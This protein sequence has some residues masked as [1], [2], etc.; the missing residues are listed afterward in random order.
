M[1]LR[2]HFHPPLSVTHPWKAFHSAWANAITKQLNEVL[3]ESYYAIPDVPRGDE[4]V[5]TPLQLRLAGSVDDPGVH[6][7]AVHIL[8][9][10]G[11]PRLRAAIELVSPQNKDCPRSRLPLAA[12]C[13][14]YLQRAVSVVLVDTVT[15]CHGNLHA[16]I[17]QMLEA[18]AGLAGDSPSDLYAAAYRAVAASGQ[19][20]LEI[21]L[22]V[23]AVGEELP[24]LP[25]W[26][27]V[28]LCLPLPLESR[29][30]AAVHALRIA[31]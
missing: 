27:A 31:R 2:D 14:S 28:D 18:S 13:I 15:S 24:T 6:G 17:V 26:L 1:P 10:E 29:Y 19:S 5:G 3:P 8:Q 20:R 7:V 23:L 25:L 21:W 4:A 12:K 30:A 16:E 11:R 9:D 22:K